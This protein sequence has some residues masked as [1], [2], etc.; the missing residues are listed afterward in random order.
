MS[1]LAKLVSVVPQIEHILVSKPHQC[2]LLETCSRAGYSYEVLCHTPPPRYSSNFGNHRTSISRQ[3]LR[4]LGTAAKYRAHDFIVWM[5][6]D[7]WTILTPLHDPLLQEQHHERLVLLDF[8][9]GC[10]CVCYAASPRPINIEQL[11]VNAPTGV[12]HS[13][14]DGKPCKSNSALPY[15]QQQ[16][17]H[18]L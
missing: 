13:G 2:V 10:G 3:A 7:G 15:L 6:V 1:R 9:K 4:L 16:Q 11:E 17:A 8:L 12:L 14:S 18:S 5:W